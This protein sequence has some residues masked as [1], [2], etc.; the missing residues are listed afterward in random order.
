MPVIKLY[1]S[2]RKMAG[3]NETKT[4]AEVLDAAL[5][6]LVQRHPGLVGAILEIGPVI[7]VRPHIIITI[8]GQLTG[9][10]DTRLAPE[11]SIAIFPPIAGG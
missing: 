3:L 9:D 8:N 1:A 5:T 10:L 2:L 7:T 6:D 4:S 11:D